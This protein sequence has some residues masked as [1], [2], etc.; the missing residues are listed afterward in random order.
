MGR[1]IKDLKRDEITLSTQYNPGLLMQD[2][3]I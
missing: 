3:K 2:G 1:Q